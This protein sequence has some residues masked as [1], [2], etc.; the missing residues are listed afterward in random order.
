[1]TGSYSLGRAVVRARRPLPTRV[2]PRWFASQGRV[3]TGSF[4]EGHDVRFCCGLSRARGGGQMRI[5]RLAVLP[6]RL[7]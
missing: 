7:T 2:G 6:V 3:V 1:M 5:A 4:R